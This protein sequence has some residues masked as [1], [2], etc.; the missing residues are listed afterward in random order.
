MTDNKGLFGRLF[1]NVSDLHSIASVLGGMFQFATGTKEAKESLGGLFSHEDEAGM[2]D[3]LNQRIRPTDPRG[4]DRFMEWYDWA[5]PRQTT[6]QWIARRI[7][8]TSFRK[9]ILSFPVPKQPSG[10]N[11]RVTGSGVQPQ[12]N[13][14]RVVEIQRMITLL[15]RSGNQALLDDCRSRDIPVPPD[16]IRDLR[17]NPQNQNRRPTLES[18]GESLIPN[19][20]VSWQLYAVIGGVVV[21][22]LVIALVMTSCNNPYV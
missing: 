18:F 11:S 5:F 20:L 14:G 21:M 1:R 9:Y 8:G 19:F 6:L 17:R 7:F 15:N 10:G 4:A 12:G 22:M 3:I 13:D 16:W 2:A